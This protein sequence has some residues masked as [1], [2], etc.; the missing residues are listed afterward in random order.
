MLE[1]PLG[2]HKIDLGF[3]AEIL[4]Y[5]DLESQ[6]TE[7][8]FVLGNVLLDF[9]GGLKVKLKEDFAQTSDPPGTELTGRIKST[10]NVLSPA[11]EYGLTGATPSGSTTRGPTCASPR[12]STSSTATSTPWG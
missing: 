9:P 3:R 2:R 12:S 1:L 6:D 5:V 8:Y 4:R 11:V 10:T 7:H